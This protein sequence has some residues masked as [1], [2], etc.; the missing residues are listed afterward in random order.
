MKKRRPR[1]DDILFISAL[2][3]IL[4][5]V[6]FLLYTT[7]TFVGAPRV[8]PILIMAVGGLFLYFALVRGASFSFFFAGLLLALEGSFI[9]ASM[10]LGWKITKSWPLGMALAGL[11]GLISGLA[12]KKRLKAFYAVPSIG[13]AVLGSLFSLFSF[14]LAKVNFKS[15]IAVWW[16]SLLIAGGVSLFV[17]YGAG[18][19]G[20]ART[21]AARSE[22]R[23]GRD[24]DPSSRP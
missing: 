6:A 18:T 4:L 3:A 15:F 16:P 22:D 14:G 11:A 13:F 19:E 10:L 7:H 2:V 8:W 20:R 17:A 1:S 21:H 23:S 24:R 9:L 12:A 5:G